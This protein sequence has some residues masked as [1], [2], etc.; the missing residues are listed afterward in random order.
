ML[1][2][3][4][5]PL[6]PALGLR[7]ARRNPPDPEFL[8]PTADLGGRALARSRS[9]SESQQSYSAQFRPQSGEC[10]L[11]AAIPPIPI[12]FCHSNHQS[13]D[14]FSGARS[15]WCAMRSSVDLL[16]ISLRC[17]ANKVWG[18]TR[19]ATSRQNLPAQPIGLSGESTALVVVEAHSPLAE[20]L[21]R[22]PVLLAKVIDD[23][24]HPGHTV[25]VP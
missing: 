22:N 11:D 12:L 23:L 9:G 20:L 13:L 1:R 19:V 6:N 25:R 4:E 15:T 24:Q 3:L 8:Q 16:A 21:A 7:R 10:A 17:Q 18:F 2:G 5:T 14:F